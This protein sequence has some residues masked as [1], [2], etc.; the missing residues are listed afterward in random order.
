MGLKVARESEGVEL[1]TDSYGYLNGTC[2]VGEYLQDELGVGADEVEAGSGQ[3]V[4][5][6]TFES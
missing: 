1:K 3:E 6:E 2:R 5:R 4:H